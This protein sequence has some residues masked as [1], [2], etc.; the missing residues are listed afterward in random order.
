MSL[1][2]TQVGVL[3][4]EEGNGIQVTLTTYGDPSYQRIINHV[5]QPEIAF[6]GFSE[7]YDKNQGNNVA[8]IILYDAR[9]WPTGETYKRSD[10][11]WSENLT[12]GQ[13]IEFL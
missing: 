9:G 8:G 6:A 4:D 11:T 10:F 1:Q 3:K 13:G 7:V 12:Y 5:I 2:G